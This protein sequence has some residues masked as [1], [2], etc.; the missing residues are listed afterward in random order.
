MSKTAIIVGTQSGCGKT[1]IM[2]ALLQAL[3]NQPTQVQAFKAGP[4]FLDPFWHQAITTQ[5]SY[6]LD[7]KMMG[8][9]ACINQLYL[10][11]KKSQI[12]LI[13]GAM[14]LFDG[15]TGVGE[16]GSSAHLAK[17]LEISVILVVDAKG[18]SGSIVPL[19][20]GFCDYATQ[21]GFKISGIIA[22]R[23]GSPHHAQLL[24]ALLA[25]HHLP[26][27]LGWMKKNAPQ[28]PERH[29]G[30][31]RPEEASFPD[32]S[33]FFYLDS[34]RLSL[35]LTAFEKQPSFVFQYKPLLKGKTIAIANDAA[36]CFIYPSN[37][38][39]LKAQGAEIHFFSP[40]KGESIPENTD[41][42]WLPGGYPELYAEELSNS[43]SW[44]AIKEF[45]NR[46]KPVLAECGGA[47]LLGKTLIDLDGKSWEMAGI[48]SYTSVMKNR[49]VSLGYRNEENGMRGHEFH[50]SARI[51]DENLS[52]CFNLNRGDKGMAYKNVR[53]SYIHWYF[54][55]E[56][57]VIAEWFS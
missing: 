3:K 28:L 6:N 15:A 54:A 33:E 17:V 39:C 1:T 52:P 9:Q 53:A 50:H 40:I 27:L 38:D 20:S 10:H 2:L 29:L 7:T 31:K 26:L 55:S 24:E 16:L 5:A 13:E 41:A 56:P 11:S 12:T 32:F 22:N 57:N 49:L 36:C 42:L 43:S 19:V 23:V 35:A 8:E 48:F 21:L 46:N 4:D 25:K 37:I 18:M 44:H 34:Q 47:M 14:G 51:N 30:L 45:I